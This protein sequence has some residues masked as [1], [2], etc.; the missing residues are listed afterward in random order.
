MTLTDSGTMSRKHSRHRPDPTPP[1]YTTGE[2]LELTGLSFRVLDYWLRTGAV[3]LADGT[4]PGS[5][6]SRRY[7]HDEVAAIQRLVERYQRAT[8]EIEAIRNGTAWLEE[9]SA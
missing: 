2:V 6:V 3:V 9:A 5:G 8:T 1:Y 4:T 7:S